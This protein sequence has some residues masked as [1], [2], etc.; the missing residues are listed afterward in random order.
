[1]EY[2]LGNPA[3]NSQHQMAIFGTADIQFH[4]APNA[5]APHGDGDTFYLACYVT[6]S[7]CLNR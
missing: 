5:V 2:I 6:G 4:S 7:G 3:V 1:M